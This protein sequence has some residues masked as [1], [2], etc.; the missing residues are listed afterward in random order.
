[1]PLRTALLALL[2]LTF[3]VTRGLHAHN[4]HIVSTESVSNITID[5]DLSDWPREMKS[6]FI[7]RTI[8]LCDG[9]PEREGLQRSLSSWGATTKRTHSTS[10]SKLKTTQSCLTR[11]EMK[12]GVLL[13]V[14]RSSLLSATL[15]MTRHRFNSSIAENPASLLDNSFND[16]LAKHAK[17]ARSVR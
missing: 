5:G 8:F 6:H 12:H 10:H 9:T 16:A 14:A 4:G 1:M 13:M 11:S 15:A 3:G 2:A 7:S 17:A